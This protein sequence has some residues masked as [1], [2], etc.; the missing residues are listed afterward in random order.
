MAANEPIPRDVTDFLL[1]T[2]ASI[3]EL[4]ALLLMRRETA[5]WSADALAQRLYISSMEAEHVLRTLMSLG[6][7]NK[8]AE[9]Y[10]YHCSSS[11][12]DAIVA[13]T[14]EVHA[15]QLIPVTKLIHEHGRKIRRFADAF[16][17]RRDP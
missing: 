4:E 7:L 5:S 2:I 12:L 13:K 11:E 14:A 8:D 16:R 9:G 10:S 6:F 3:A 17:F 15:R 1:R